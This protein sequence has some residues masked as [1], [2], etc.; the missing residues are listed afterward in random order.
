MT[1]DEQALLRGILLDPN[2]D[3]PRLVLADWLEENGDE[4]RAAGIRDRVARPGEISSQTMQIQWS[5][6]YAGREFVAARAS[7]PPERPRL[8]GFGLSECR[9]F[10]FRLACPHRLFTLKD[11][12]A[13]V[14]SA[15]PITRVLIGDTSYF[16]DRRPYQCLRPECPRLQP[17]G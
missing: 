15:H 5:P 9:G 12:A 11:F 2:A 4:A 13:G 17:W 6:P 14:F 16:G 10:A 7:L 3:L 1:D 8:L